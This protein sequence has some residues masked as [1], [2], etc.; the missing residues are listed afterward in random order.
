MSD[1]RLLEDQVAYYRARAGEYDEW[2]FRE[3]R[4]DRGAEHRRQ[5]FAEVETIRRALSREI[6][7]L[8]VLELAC[9]TGLW[10]ERL[11]RENRS[12]VAVDSSPEAIGVN[13]N[14]V[15]S[16]N[17]Q[18]EV[19][20]L[21]SW[22]APTQFDAVFFSFWLSHVPPDRVEDFWRSVRSALKPNGRVFFVDSLLEETSTAKD[23]H[24]IDDES[25][26][27][28]RKLNDGREFDIV[29]VFYRPEQLER[30]LAELGWTGKVC[31]AG[32]FFY[33]GCV[34]AA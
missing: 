1:D 3:G 18:Y 29:K 12:V 17:V 4:Y 33:Y 25:G 32:K 5:W 11:A 26:V 27:V 34:V 8:D 13:R 20:D 23:H 21:F 9:G 14:R 16:A 30:L 7:N 24:R 19:A 31:S 28:R 15:H 6:N 22:I 10:T 2:F